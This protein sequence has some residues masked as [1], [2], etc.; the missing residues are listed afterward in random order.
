MYSVLCSTLMFNVTNSIKRIIPGD[1]LLIFYC[2]DT[3]FVKLRS[4]S[5][6]GEGQVR[7]R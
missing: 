2:L 6:S 3:V 4:R 1:F 7:V 5:R